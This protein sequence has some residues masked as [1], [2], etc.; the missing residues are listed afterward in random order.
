MSQEITECIYCG[1]HCDLS[2]PGCI[3]GIELAKKVKEGNFDFKSVEKKEVFKC[4][5]YKVDGVPHV[6]KGKYS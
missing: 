1:K 3:R 2:A 5:R 6:R 4:G